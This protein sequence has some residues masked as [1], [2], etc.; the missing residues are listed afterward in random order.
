[1]E[2]LTVVIT[3]QFTQHMVAQLADQ[4]AL[5]EERFRSLEGYR[6]VI[7]K[8]E[9]TTKRALQDVGSPTHIIP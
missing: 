8:P 9:V 2:S 6:V 1:M 5:Y 4:A 3:E 7:S